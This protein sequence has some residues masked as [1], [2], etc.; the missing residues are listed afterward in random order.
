MCRAQQVAG[1]ALWIIREGFLEGS[2]KIAIVGGGPAG[3][4]FADLMKRENPA[5]D[6]CIYEQNPKG[7]TWGFGV[8]FSDRALEFLRGDDEDMYQYLMPHME[9]WPNLTIVHRDTHVPIDG[10][11]FA[12]IGRLELLNLMQERVEARGVKIQYDTVISDLDDLADAD[13]IVGSD[14]VNSVVRTAYEKDFGTSIDTRSNKFIWYG[15]T[16]PFDSLTLTFRTNDDG[17][18]CAHHYRYKPDM[19]TFLVEVDHETWVKAGFETMTT[20]DTLAYC[21]QVFAPDLD[22][23]PIVSNNSNW[24]NFPFIWNEKWHHNNIV[25]MGD[26]LRTAHFSIGS[27]TRLAME[28]AV[29]L[30]KA[31]REKGNDLDAAFRRFEEIRRPPM[32]AICKAANISLRWYE[33]MAS[34]MDLSPYEFAHSY[35]MRSKRLSEENLKKIAPDFMARYEQNRVA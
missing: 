22:G 8:V 32:E 16:K 4:Y 15:T 3:L 28:D 21:E 24:R 33:E 35:M 17:V 23:H 2:V 13:L 10:N 27:G 19:S 29:A 11:G 6:I 9:T 12:A 25:L 1:P 5:H 31:F 14:G 34:L 20:D 26:A 18:F 7:A 30:Y